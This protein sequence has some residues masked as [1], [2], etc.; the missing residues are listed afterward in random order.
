MNAVELT[1]ITKLFTMKMIVM[2]RG[3]K[4]TAMK[5]RGG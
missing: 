1:V 3:E 5:Q 2:S 4:M